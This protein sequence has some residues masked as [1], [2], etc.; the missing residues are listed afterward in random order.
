MTA[1]IEGLLRELEERGDPAQARKLKV[2]YKTP[3]KVL[4]VPTPALKRAL[5]AWAAREGGPPSIEGLARLFASGVCEARLAAVELALARRSDWDERWMELF[6]CWARTT[7][8]SWHLADKV[9]RGIL[10]PLLLSG[11]LAPARLDELAASSEVWPWRAGLS[12]LGLSLAQGD[13]DWPRFER[14]ARACVG[15]GSRFALK[16]P[17]LN[18]LRSALRSAFHG[19]PSRAK[20]FLARHEPE[21]PGAAAAVLGPDGEGG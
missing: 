12:A 5:A 4:G 1:G 10:G 16:R 8:T 9:G 3:E 17:A 2:R 18:G 14:F 15:P 11:A 7:D 13:R 6:L 19:C 21:L 20:D